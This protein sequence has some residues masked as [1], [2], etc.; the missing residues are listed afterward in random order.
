MPADDK[1][2][3]SIMSLCQCPHP[4]SQ[5]LVSQ[6]TMIRVNKNKLKCPNN[7]STNTE[8]EQQPA[9]ADQHS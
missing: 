9:A 8:S 3:Q 1:R 6:S 5:W 7:T 4:L 2:L